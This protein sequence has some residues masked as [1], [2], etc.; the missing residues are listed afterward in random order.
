MPDRVWLITGCSS[1]FGRAIAEAVIDE[2]ERL[3][4]TARDPDSIRDLAERGGDRTH[5]TALD[6]TDSARHPA[7]VDEA[8]D[9]FGR[10]DV[11]VNNAGYGLLG[12]LEEL[13]EE[14]IRRNVETNFIGPL[15]LMKAVLPAMREQGSGHIINMSAIAALANHVGFAS[16][17]GAKA[18]LELAGDAVAQEAQPLGIRV[19]SVV[20]GPF[21]T[22]FVGRS[23]ERP[24]RRIDAY[25]RTVGQFA[26]YLEKMDGSQPGDPAR[27]GRAILELVGAEKP[28]SR[29]FL[30]AFAHDQARRRL[31]AIGSELDSW[32]KTGRS[33]DFEA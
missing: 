16:Y 12:A 23:M 4:A 20:P 7:V 15:M 30:G 5:A 13:D 24:E 32:E 1:G 18:G 31:K 11:L 9:R 14:A 6:V 22:G 27:A 2:G 17:G 26:G 33:T 10:I 21:R 25:Q 19:T 8:L 28:P 3:V 29:L